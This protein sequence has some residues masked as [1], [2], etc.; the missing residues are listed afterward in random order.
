[1]LGFMIQRLL[2]ALVVMLVYFCAGVRRRLRRRQPDRRA[3]LTDA[4]QQ[5]REA[6][7]KAYGLDQPLWKQYF[8][9]LAPASPQAISGAPSSTTCRCWI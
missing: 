7:I 5:I 8:D 2:Q 3:D 1:M 6:A 9:F 4:T